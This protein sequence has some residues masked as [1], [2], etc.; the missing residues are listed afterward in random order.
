MSTGP[1]QR[2]NLIATAML[3]LIVRTD[4]GGLAEVEIVDYS[5]LSSIFSLLLQ[6]IFPVNWQ[7][8]DH[9]IFPQPLGF[10]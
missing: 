4:S 8:L 1:D 9:Q 10:L 6:I 3:A 7:A 5:L 2:I